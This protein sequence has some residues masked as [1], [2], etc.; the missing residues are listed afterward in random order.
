MGASVT[1]SKILE[2]LTALRTETRDRLATEET[3]RVL[4]EARLV[5]VEKATDKNSKTLHGNGE[6]G[7]DEL[8]REIYARVQ[9]MEKKRKE[10]TATFRWWWEKVISPFIM[11]ILI[12]WAILQ[13]QLG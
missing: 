12:A 4:I 8:I 1:N 10:E 9:A 13:L 11:P 7:M 3:R 5:A 2:E 6:P